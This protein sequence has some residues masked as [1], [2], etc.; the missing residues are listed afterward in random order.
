[1][2]Q[3]LQRLQGVQGLELAK[4]MLVRLVVVVVLPRV[5]LI[6]WAA[7]AAAGVVVK[8]EVVMQ[9]RLA[10][11]APDR[12]RCKRL[13]QLANCTC[14]RLEALVLDQGVWPQPQPCLLALHPQDPV[15][16]F[17]YQ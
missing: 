7:V 3:Q 4:V 6:G 9:R 5:V 11:E 8:A 16:D 13:L 15:S 1:M 14:A 12:S 10:V 2:W 17:L